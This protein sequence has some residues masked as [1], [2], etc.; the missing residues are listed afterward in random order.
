MHAASSTGNNP[1]QPGSAGGGQAYR[2]QRPR[3]VSPRMLEETAAN[4]NVPEDFHTLDLDGDGVLQEA[5]Y[6]AAMNRPVEV[7]PKRT[8]VKRRR[9]TSVIAMVEDQSSPET[10]SKNPAIDSMVGRVL[11]FVGEQKKNRSD[12]KRDSAMRRHQI[13]V[14]RAKGALQKD[15]LV[16]RPAV[17][18]DVI[19]RYE[20]KKT[21][22]ILLFCFLLYFFAFILITDIFLKG[23]RRPGAVF[24]MQKANQGWIEKV[25]QANGNIVQD[26]ERMEDVWPW[27]H[28][29]VDT[30]YVRKHV[31]VDAPTLSRAKAVASTVACNGTGMNTNA[32]LRQCDP[33]FKLY[34]VDRRSNP[35]GALSTAH[36]DAAAV[37]HGYNRV[38]HGILIRQ[39]RRKTSDCSDSFEHE[40]PWCVTHDQEDT[41]AFRG[42][43]SG[44][45]YNRVADLGEHEGSGG[46][47]IGISTHPNSNVSLADNHALLRVLEV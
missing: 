5:E 2:R 43:R 6:M 46:Y 9:R 16:V 31:G 26:V 42:K 14:A 12:S 36:S 33:F 15:D 30:V 24:S 10:R 37:V 38:V 28:D 27:L 7:Q 1:I 47:L 32:D 17:I 21:G 25:G 45:T 18:L 22:L 34:G 11:A 19:K 8:H 35:R 44:W 41:A 13:N 20:D 29:F 39:R 3:V 40:L 4:A 23:N